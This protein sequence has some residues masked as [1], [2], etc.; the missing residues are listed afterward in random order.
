MSLYLN[1]PMISMEK[2]AVYFKILHQTQ[3]T[4]N[5]GPQNRFLETGRHIL[6]PMLIVEVPFA[7]CE[8]LIS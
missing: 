1:L 4:L 2:E 5:C 7:I 6:Q 3:V 8:G